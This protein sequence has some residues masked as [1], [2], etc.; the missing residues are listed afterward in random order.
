MKRSCRI[1]KS[2]IKLLGSPTSCEPARQWNNTLVSIKRSSTRVLFTLSSCLSAGQAIGSA[3]RQFKLFASTSRFKLLISASSCRFSTLFK[4]FTSTSPPSVKKQ[5]VSQHVFPFTIHDVIPHNKLSL[6]HTHKHL[7]ETVKRQHN[8]ASSVQQSTRS[9]RVAHAKL[10]PIINVFLLR[11]VIKAT[12][13]D[14]F[15][16]TVSYTHIRKRLF[17]QQGFVPGSLIHKQN[18]WIVTVMFVICVSCWKAI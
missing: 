9:Q 10:S 2:R 7:I 6:Q 8:E 3:T 17:V 11:H 1:S 5:A 18:S 13:A 12:P 14:S 15:L 16:H 4:L